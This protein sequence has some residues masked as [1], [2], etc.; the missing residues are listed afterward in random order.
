MRHR[1]AHSASGA[2]LIGLGFLLTAPDSGASQ[3]LVRSGLSADKPLSYHLSALSS[4]SFFSRSGGIW[5]RHEGMWAFRPTSRPDWQAYFRCQAGYGCGGFGWAPHRFG[6]WLPYGYAGWDLVPGG[7]MW[8]PGQRMFRSRAWD[9]CWDLWFFS[10]SYM[11]GAYGP[12]PGLRTP[13]A[14]AIWDGGRAATSGIHRP[15]GREDWRPPADISTGDLTRPLVHPVRAVPVVTVS[16]DGEMEPSGR[17]APHRPSID[18]VMPT[19]LVETLFEPTSIQ[20]VRQE[21]LKR[22]EINRLEPTRKGN[23]LRSGTDLSRPPTGLR[24][25][26]PR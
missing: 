2:T 21:S 23:R 9:L 5:V 18:P 12:G 17:E 26:S 3:D 20:R 4:N 6:S 10:P 22:P 19:R 15:G 7:W 24:S 11:H 25:S 1:R 8:F 16:A 14:P 13:F